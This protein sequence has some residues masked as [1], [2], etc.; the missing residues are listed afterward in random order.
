[1]SPWGRTR[2]VGT[3]WLGLLPC[4]PSWPEGR[5]RKEGRQRKKQ[6]PGKKQASPPCKLVGVVFL[7]KIKFLKKVFLNSD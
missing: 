2:G 4:K 7:N 6:P 3:G 1:M 5:E